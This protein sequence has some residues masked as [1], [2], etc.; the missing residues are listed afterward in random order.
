[1][2]AHTRTNL[3]RVPDRSPFASLDANTIARAPSS[4]ANTAT[5]CPSPLEV[6][7]DGSPSS[8]SSSRAT[9]SDVDDDVSDGMTTSSA[10]S[11]RDE[12]RAGRRMAR[13]D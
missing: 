13:D 6:D 10:P 3:A 8:S 11:V 9:R 4:R 2:D 5:P 12:R 1:V 7:G